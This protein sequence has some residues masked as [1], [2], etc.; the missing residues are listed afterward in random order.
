M[1]F[2]QFPTGSQGLTAITLD[3][4]TKYIVK[5]SDGVTVL[6][7]EVEL[8]GSKGQQQRCMKAGTFL[9][10]RANLANN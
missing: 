5:C 9:Y 4:V 7:T 3:K 8:P 2:W 1:G 10:S 6:A